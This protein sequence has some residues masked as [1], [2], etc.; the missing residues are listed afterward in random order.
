[1]Q[2]TLTKPASKSAFEA[3]TPHVARVSHK[4]VNSYLVADEG[5]RQ[6][7]LVDTG[8]KTSAGHILSAVE[9]RFGP[10]A[11]PE[12]IVLTHGHF[13]HVGAAA[14]LARHW[15][16]PVYAHRLETPYLNGRSKYPPADPTVGGGLL[17][18]L[19]RFLSRGP[20]NLGG[21]LRVLP[22]NGDV[23][24]LMPHW[25]WI[26]TPGHSPGH[27]SL[28]D[29][30][31]RVL[32][33]GDAF[34]TTKQESAA[35][36]LAQRQQ[37]NGPPAFLT[38][39]WSAARDSV[40]QLSLLNPRIAATGHGIPMGGE[41]LQRQLR[42]LVANFENVA[43]PRRGRYVHEPALMDEHGVISVPPPISDPVPRMAVAL[44]AMA[45]VATAFV[46][47]QRNRRSRAS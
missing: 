38:P 39:D 41:A 14:R 44:V 12:A 28:F 42:F 11:S 37:V 1:M 6:W 2:N 21:R 20:I 4:I 35:A 30:R 45:A 9:E 34:V 18:V 10:H 40:R 19:S 43:V 32:I 7:I 16:V 46:L 23:P 25:R 26:H 27:V 3:V 47:V 5:S 29:E 33:A 13:D 15:N 22:E 8:L 36:V 31:E 17:T 24:G